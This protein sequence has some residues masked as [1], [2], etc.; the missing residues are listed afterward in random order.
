VPSPLRLTQLVGGCVLL[1]VGVTLLLLAAVGSDGFSTFVYG[2][3]LATGL[4]FVVVNLLVSATFL[5]V[6]W[7][8]GVRPGAGTL[9]QIVIVGGV[10]DLGLSTAPAPDALW[11][12]VLLCA[13]ALPVLATGISTYL[14]SQLGAGPVEAGALAWDPPL[15]FAVSYNTIQLV[16]AL[17][18]WQLGAPLGVGTVAVVVLLGPLVS[19]VGRLLRL[20]LHQPGPRTGQV[21]ELP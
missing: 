5:A 15:R 1:G 4:P 7:L 17:I 14:G 11:L 16:T 19:L 10:V 13:A 6:A 18:G 2:L 9:V 3:T 21:P 12:R 20:D 8:R